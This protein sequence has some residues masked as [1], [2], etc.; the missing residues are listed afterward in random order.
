MKL[1]IKEMMNRCPNMVNGQEANGIQKKY[2]F[3]C[4]ADL[5]HPNYEQEYNSHSRGCGCPICGRLKMSDARSLTTEELMSRCP[6]VVKGQDVRGVLKKY[7]FRCL[8]GLDHPNYLQEF[9]SHWGRGQNCP[10]CGLIKSGATRRLTMREMMKD[11]PDMVKGQEAKKSIGKYWFRCLAGLR[12]PNYMQSHNN[13]SKGEGCPVCLESKG[14][15]FIAKTLDALGLP[16]AREVK[17]DGC[18]GKRPL[19][20]DFFLPFQRTLVEYQGEQHYKPV[21]FW[22]GVEKLHMVRN[23]DEIKRR[24]AKKNNHK[25]IEIPHYRKNLDAVLISRLQEGL[26]K[27]A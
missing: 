5:N 8:A 25:L 16:Y 9:N 18:V 20:F 2:W 27:A 4:S 17:M 14:E 13:H 19:A 21:S 12:H 26:F 6:D 23:N 10:I 11:C 3:R 1:T 24:W 22:G 15:K 7:W